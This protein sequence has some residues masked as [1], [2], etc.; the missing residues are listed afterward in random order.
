MAAVS[1]N[2][3]FDVLGDVVDKYNNTFHRSIKM[4]PFDVTSDSFAEY[5]EGSKVTQ[6]KFKFGDHVRISKYKNNFPEGST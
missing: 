5:N 2:G 6:P 4:K 3:C 1:K